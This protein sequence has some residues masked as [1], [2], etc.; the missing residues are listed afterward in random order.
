MMT[1]RTLNRVARHESLERRILLTSTGTAGESILMSRT[2][3]VTAVEQEFDGTIDDGQL[4]GELT[5]PATVTFADV[6]IDLDYP[7]SPVN[8][9]E[10]SGSEEMPGPPIRSYA[11]DGWKWPDS[12][13]PVGYYINTSNLPAGVNG[14]DYISAV[15]NTFQAWE[16][17]PTTT[18]RFFRIGFGSQFGTGAADGVTTVGFGTAVSGALAH[19]TT[20]SDGVGV[21]EFDVVLGDDRASW[22]ANPS[23]PGGNQVDVWATNTHEV[24]HGLGLGHSSDTDASMYSA[25]FVGS[26]HQRDPN[27]DDIAGL[28]Q[29]YP[30]PSNQA[31]PI[32]N[33]MWASNVLEDRTT[34]SWSASMLT[35]SA[36]PTSWDGARVQATSRVLDSSPS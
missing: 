21:T 25:I 8:D 7:L 10:E 34:V 29:L 6:P 11:L 32:P 13:I 1:Q 30:A 19:A 22:S 33:S 31:P 23:G 12:R 18:I 15:D 3:A 16:D 35:C 5:S 27:S 2:V 20:Y 9:S 26:T 17:I 24:G 14:S 4:H 36:S 28:E